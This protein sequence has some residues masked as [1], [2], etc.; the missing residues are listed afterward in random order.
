MENVTTAVTLLLIGGLH[1][2]LFVGPLTLLL[3]IFLVRVPKQHRLIS[4]KRLWIL[5]VPFV[6]IVWL[7]FAVTRVSKSFQRHFAADGEQKQGDCGYALGLAMV[8]AVWTMAAAPMVTYLMQWEEQVDVA[9][10]GCGL[11]V[12]ALFAAYVTRMVSTARALRT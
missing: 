9:V 11:T 10:V 7:Y 8:I 2:F 6:H 5:A 1:T 4:V 3:M 12:F